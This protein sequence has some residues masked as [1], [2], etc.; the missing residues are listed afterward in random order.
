MR[1]LIDGQQRITTISRTLA[2]DE[3][4]EVFFNPVTETFSLLNAA[5]RNDP[6]WVR[7]ADLFDDRRYRELIREL[8][9]SRRGEALQAKYDKLRSIRDYEVP[10]V[11]MVDHNFNEAVEAFTRIN[12]LA[13]RLKQQDIESAR[14]AE[15]HAG[16][17]SDDVVPFMRT[18]E[19]GGF[20]RLNVMHLFRVCAFIARPDGR[21]RTPLHEL[22]RREVDSAWR[23]TKRATRDAQ[24]LVK[25]ELGLVNMDILW[26]GAFLVPV[27][28]LLG[29]TSPRDRDTKGMIGWLALAALKHRYSK[30]TESALDQDLSACRKPDPIA[31]LLSNLRNQSR[32]PSLLAKPADFAGSLSDKSG[33]LAAYIACKQSGMKDLWTGQRI[34]MHGEIDR[35]HVLPRRQFNERSRSMADTVANIA[36]ITSEV[37]NAISF[38]G[39][40]VYLAQVNPQYLKSQCI[41]LTPGLW[42]IAKSD[43]FFAARRKLLAQSFNDFLRD[44]L[45]GRRL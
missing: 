39:P 44:A 9:N 23:E 28:A 38:S 22:S 25:S 41:P 17:I 19:D 1:W 32:A 6:K 20:S 42:R 15:T 29:T 8:P 36:F 14:V 30:S 34:I 43:E 3:D 31:T 4:I 7:I 21:V 45:P 40:E 13:T 33:L 5:I 24:N 12:T 10:V 18:I 11:R 26:S 35:H 37:N 16:L 2:G 27:I